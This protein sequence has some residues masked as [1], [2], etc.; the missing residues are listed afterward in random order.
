MIASVPMPENNP[1]QPRAEIRNSVPNRAEIEQARDVTIRVF[2]ALCGLA[3]HAGIIVGASQRALTDAEYA[4]Q[5]AGALGIWWSMTG[6]SFRKLDELLAESGQAV[7]PFAVFY[8]SFTAGP[9]VVGTRTYPNV[10]AAAHDVLQ[11]VLATLQQVRVDMTPTNLDTTDY[12]RV[13]HAAVTAVALRDGVVS[14]IGLNYE[15][16]YST[17]VSLIRVEA[18]KALSALP[19]LTPAIPSFAPEELMVIEALTKHGKPLTQEKLLHSAGLN[20]SSGTN[21][22]LL[23][24]MRSRGWLTNKGK[25]YGLPEW[26][27]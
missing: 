16:D 20:T 13:Q 19:P 25:G 7:N 10:H 23:A 5:Y 12:E 1:K 9:L 21:K 27:K 17:W 26:G 2:D 3:W 18:G 22:D 24:K 11:R 15:R 8:D 14:V 6:D 4:K